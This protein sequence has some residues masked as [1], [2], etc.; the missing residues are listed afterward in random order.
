MLAWVMNLGF[1][2]SP[3]GII[4]PPVGPTPAGKH[5]KRYGV[6]EGWRLL[7]FDTKADADA[8]KSSQKQAKS[9]VKALKRIRTVDP[10]QVINLPELKRSLPPPQAAQVDQMIREHRFEQVA[11]LPGIAAQYEA[12]RLAKEQEDEMAMITEVVKAH[13]Q[14]SIEHVLALHGVLNDLRK[15]RRLQ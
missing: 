10:V 6:V 2:A 14:S 8:F 9:P 1:G 3:S 13:R 15:L 4:P 5:R 12:Q 11:Q 7:L